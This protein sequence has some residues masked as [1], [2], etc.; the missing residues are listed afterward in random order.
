MDFSSNGTRAKVAVREPRAY[1]GPAPKRRFLTQSRIRILHCS[2]IRDSPGPGVLRERARATWPARV[3]RPRRPARGARVT[4]PRRR[5]AARATAARC[6]AVRTARARG[7]RRGAARP[8]RRAL[9]ARGAVR[10]GLNGACGGDRAARAAAGAGRRRLRVAGFAYR[11]T[12]L[13]SG[14][15]HKSGAGP[16]ILTHSR[17]RILHSRRIRRKAGHGV[18]TRRHSR[19]A[20]GRGLPRRARP[21]RRNGAAEPAQL[22]R[23]LL[24]LTARRCRARSQR[25]GANLAAADARCARP[26][27]CRAA[28]RR[29]STQDCRDRYTR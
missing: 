8:E 23:G 13:A 24:A 7:A 12:P 3:T 14:A 11:T 19:R 20:R 27:S 5:R 10:R 16:P 4:R 1:Q 6:G 22:A 21:A 18:R 17:I 25:S 2:R 9:A 28:R 15:T 26:G 29:R